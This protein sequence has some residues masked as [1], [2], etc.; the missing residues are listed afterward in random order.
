MGSEETHSPHRFRCFAAG[1]KGPE[2]E[3]KDKKSITIWDESGEKGVDVVGRGKIPQRNIGFFG[4]ETY[5]NFHF[6][7]LTEVT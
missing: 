6:P 5:R 2:I 3:K 4:G 1:G 7:Q